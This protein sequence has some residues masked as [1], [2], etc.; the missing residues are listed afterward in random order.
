MTSRET[1]VVLQDQELITGGNAG[2]HCPLAPAVLWISAQLPAVILCFKANE[3]NSVDLVD[4]LTFREPL[5]DSKWQKIWTPQTWEMVYQ[6]HGQE[7]LHSVKFSDDSVCTQL[8]LKKY[9]ICIPFTNQNI[10]SKYLF[11]NVHWRKAK[12]AAK[13]DALRKRVE[14]PGFLITIL[15]TAFRCWYKDWELSFSSAP[16]IFTPILPYKEVISLS[17]GNTIYCQQ[18]SLTIW[19]Q[20]LR[21]A[22]SARCSAVQ[23]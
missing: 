17:P 23:E 18:Q 19:K 10:P 20:Y 6:I 21:K 3:S 13:V 7:T 5:R 11:G 12:E 4:C 22:C 16:S 9:Q 8:L 2:S 14:E 1:R 15:P